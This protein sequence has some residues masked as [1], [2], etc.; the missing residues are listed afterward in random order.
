MGAPDILG[1]LAAR[2]L[3]VRPR[4]DGNLEVSPRGLL[5]DET[6][7]LI[8][9]HKAE[10]LQALVADPLPD[11][12]AEARRQRV[13]AILAENPTARYALLTY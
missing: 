12:T 2:G 5:T 1:L 9:E 3:T 8:R 7:R 10:L 11:P 13:L 6:R 4:P